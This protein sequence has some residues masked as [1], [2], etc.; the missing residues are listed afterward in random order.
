MRIFVAS[1]ITLFILTACSSLKLSPAE[2]AWPIESVIKINDDGLAKEERYSFSFN[3]KAL[4][5]EEMQDSLA[6]VGKDLRIIRNNEGYY[7]ITSKGFKNVYIFESS[8]SS[9]SLKEKITI[10]ETGLNNPF[11]NQ[12]NQF[13]ELIDGEYKAYLTKEGLQGGAK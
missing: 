8:E 4:F 9:L 10:N 13:I 1:I 2:F 11:F 6:Y 3:A 5:M 7:F 12:R